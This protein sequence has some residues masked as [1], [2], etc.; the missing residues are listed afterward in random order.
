AL[1]ILDVSRLSIDTLNAIAKVFDTYANKEFKRIPEQYGEDPVRLSFDLDFLRAL[2]PG[3]N[4]DE[5][6]TCLIDLYKRLGTVL[7][8][9]IGT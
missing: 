9:W 5:V 4:E 3:I 7:K 2:S 1:P 6:R 8:T